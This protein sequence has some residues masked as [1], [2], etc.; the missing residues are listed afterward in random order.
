[1]PDHAFNRLHQALIRL[2]EAT[3]AIH[4]AQRAD[5]HHAHPA[6]VKLAEIL[7]RVREDRD[8]LMHTINRRQED[9]L[10]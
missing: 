6:D 9:N 7:V 2:D 1:M 3:H 5:E 10:W 8:A 4:E